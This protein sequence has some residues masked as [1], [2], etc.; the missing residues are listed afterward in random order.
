MED[1]REL[2]SKLDRDGVVELDPGRTYRIRSG[3][4]L[5]RHR[6]AILGDGT[7]TL[8]LAAGDGEFHNPSSDVQDRYAPSSVGVLSEGLDDIRLA[9][10]AIRKE[11]RDGSYVK[12][13]AVRDGR[14]PTLEG[15]DVSGFSIG[16]GL[17]TLS[18]VVQGI[19]RGNQ[20]HDCHTNH[21]ERG[22]ITGIEVDNDLVRGPSR[23][24]LIEKNALRN[25]TVGPDFFGRFGY[26]TDGIN[27]ANSE[28]NGHV[29]RDNVIDR[30]GE[31]IDV[32]GSR[33]EI[34]RNVIKGSVQAAIKLVHGARD[35]IVAGNTVDGAGLAGILLSGSDEEWVRDHT[36]RNR[37]TDNSIGGIN[38]DPE[39]RAL[40]MSRW[41]DWVSW[42]TAAIFLMRQGRWSVRDN[43]IERNRIT[44]S[45]SLHF[46]VYDDSGEANVFRD[47]D[48]TGWGTGY[49]GTN[50]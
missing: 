13:V 29:L 9:G 10:F 35:S 30:V 23:G 36:A 19:V 27:I 40:L 7:S 16:G 18:S 15:L 48:A 5:R 22:Q 43:V 6:A 21:A 49:F 39:V 20:V 17:I 3:L 31:G 32:F 37:I 46:V 44:G 8:L 26:E 1:T 25:L 45:P 34:T 14:N 2:Q 12:A 47:N 38:Q 28:S 11:V 42:R 50:L 4:V 41:P 33:L 24:L